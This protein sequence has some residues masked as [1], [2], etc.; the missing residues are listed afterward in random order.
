MIVCVCNAVS[1]A[2]IQ[3]AV[4]AGAASLADLQLRLGVASQCQACV[5]CAEHCLEE[6]KHRQSM[7]NFTAA[8]PP[9]APVLSPSAG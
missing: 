2:D 8:T 6:A 5:G 4:S 9:L 1:E 3:H 7:S